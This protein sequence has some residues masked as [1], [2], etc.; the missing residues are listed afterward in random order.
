MSPREPTVL[1]K[2]NPNFVEA[3]WKEF[4]DKIGLASTSDT[5]RKEMRRAFFAGGMSIIDLMLT[6]FDDTGSPDDVTDQDL[7]IMVAIQAEFD[8]FKRDLAEGRA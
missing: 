2:N 1:D 6:I 4:S 8:Q 3:N 5:Q 7:S